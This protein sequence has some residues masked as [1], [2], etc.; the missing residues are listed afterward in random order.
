MHVDTMLC[1]VPKSSKDDAEIIAK[2]K[3]NSSFAQFA[4][5]RN[6]SLRHVA[7]NKCIHPF[8]GCP[9]P[10][11]DDKVVLHGHCNEE[12][13]KFHLMASEYKFIYLV[14]VLYCERIMDTLN[15]H[16]CPSLKVWA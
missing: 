1:L 15:C 9:V 4:V 11:Q 2:R 5:T 13:L 3:C 16:I 14:I 12:R 6:R 8:W 7:T 10:Q